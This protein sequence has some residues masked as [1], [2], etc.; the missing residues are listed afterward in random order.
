MNSA[1]LYAEM[2][3]CPDGGVAHFV[4]A[5][6]G[7]KVRF[8]IWAG[9]A[10]GMVMLLPGRTEYIEKY[11]RMIGDLTKRGFSVVVIDWRGQGLSDH[12]DGRTDLGDVVDFA[13]YQQDMAA[14]LNH[15]TVT[16]LSGPRLLF[17]H[18]MGG[19]IALRHLMDTHDFKAAVFSA[20]MWNVIMPK[21]TR[22]LVAGLSKIARAIGR[23]KA[24]VPKSN[25]DFYVLKAKFADNDLT[26]DQN[27]WDY[28]VDHIR[29]KPALGLGGASMRWFRSAL[30]EFASF[31]TSKLPD[32]PMLVMLGTDERIV[33]PE[34]IHHLVPRIP[35]AQLKIFDNARHEIWMESPEIR[36]K[37]WA[38]TDKFLDAIV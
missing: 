14:V 9:G 8:A 38:A 33:L 11:G 35:N 6:D 16:A 22:T 7:T 3:E 5:A 26:T 25:G 24:R 29:A 4:S 19:C 34:A 13:D 37:A 31:K 36:K 10:R 12:I 20:P 27:F 30:D 23:G 18:S 32:L 17:S 28:M 2:A 1:P 15:P 21:G